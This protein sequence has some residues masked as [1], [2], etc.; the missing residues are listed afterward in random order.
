MAELTVADTGPASAKPVTI[1]TGGTESAATDRLLVRLGH[2]YA[3]VGRTMVGVGCAVLAPFTNPP[4]GTAVISMIAAAF[5]AWSAV[6]LVQMFREPRP[7]VWGTDLAIVMALCLASGSLEAT[8]II[9]DQAG[10]VIGVASFTVVAL[11]WHLRVGAAAAATALIVGSYLVGAAA[12]PAPGW[13]EGVPMGVWML[14][15][16]ALSR[17]LW[18]LVRRGGRV[19]DRVIAQQ[20]ADERGATLAAARRADQRSYWATLHDTS[21]TTLLVVGLGEVRGG[22]TWL[23]PQ[24]ER[25]LVALRAVA[26]P[27]DG[28]VDLA[29][30]LRETVATSR[31]TADLQ[32]GDPVRVPASVAAA[33]AGATAEVLE[34]VRR[35][36]GVDGAQVSLQARNGRVVVTIAD[37]GQGFDPAE[38]P[39]T[40]RGLRWSVH[41]R[42]E[43]A[44]GCARVDSAPSSGTVVH[45]KWPDWPKLDG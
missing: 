40:C 12:S 3:A 23:R 45:L 10:W 35:H 27:P 6:Y 7:W 33:I 17:L 42:M 36:A 44:G 31:T 20:L 19:A 18:V 8:A 4:V 37:D 41:E 14:V 29:G 5:V 26:A 2:Q 30:C 9:S 38:V 25:D 39:M 22:E 32:L 15:E 1:G 21:A 13:T 34:N 43:G 11:Q 28:D 24:L 16:A